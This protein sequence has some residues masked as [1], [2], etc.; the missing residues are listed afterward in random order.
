M[1]F[2]D[3][4][5]E[6]PFN[7][8]R[9]DELLIQAGSIKLDRDGKPEIGVTRTTNITKIG[10]QVLPALEDRT[11]VTPDAPQDVV[12]K[13]IAAIKVNDGVVEVVVRKGPSDDTVR[14]FT[15]KDGSKGSVKRAIVYDE[16]GSKTLVLWDEAVDTFDQLT[17]I[18]V[19]L[20]KARVTIS[21]YNTLELHT[22]SDTEFIPQ[23]VSQ[24]PEDPPIQDITKIDAQQGLA[25]IQGVIQQVSEPREFTR[26]DGSAGRVM[27]MTI[28]DTTGSCPVVA[29]G[30]SVEKLIDIKEKNL[31][32]TKVFFG[33]I[34]QGNDENL[35]VHLTP[36]THIRPSSRI[37][38]LLR[39][40]E[41]QEPEEA[42]P[43]R[44]SVDYEK[45]QLSELSDEDDART[46][47]IFGKLIRLFQ[48]PPYYQACPEC[49]KKVFE[50]E[51]ATGWECSSHGTVEPQII[52]RVSGLVDDGTATIRVT[53][54]GRSGERL[55]PLSS[56]QI[57]NM[58]A[59][60]SSDEDIFDS[61]QSAVEGTNILVRGRIQ[62]QTREVQGETLQDQTLM[63][64]SVFFPD[65]KVFAENLVSELQE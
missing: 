23:E 26:S 63:A 9:G 36:Q 5:A 28:Q 16:T 41:I 34:R 44:P 31:K 12:K 29:W 45:I 43:S 8:T 21:R 24:I 3:D 52:M 40:I 65:P 35:E 49:R 10:H 38:P 62:L 20:S 59:G 33:R 54:F 53:F 13:K 7:F 14:Q 1:V 17:D 37:P 50:T 60:G 2:W 57:K 39:Q 42:Q 18:T 55:S 61:V 6:E 15:R 32:Y 22:L 51:Q 64:N 46:V 58:L 4:R 30:D 19:K 25:S 47:E 11:S 56:S 27:S 48:Q